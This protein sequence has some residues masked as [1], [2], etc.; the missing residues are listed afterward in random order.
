MSA[1]PVLADQVV[2]ITGA[3]GG[4]GYGMALACAE[5]SARV[6]VT[7]RDESQGNGVVKE[8]AERG[9]KAIFA[10][11]D[12][13]ERAEIDAAVAAALESFG[14]LDAFIHNAT[15]NRSP[16]PQLI[17]DVEA[18]LLAEHTS[19]ALRAAY[20]SAQAS[21]DALRARRGH[22]VLLTS[23]AGIEGSPTLPLYSAV[24]A[25]QRAFMKSLAKEWGPEGIQVNAISPLAA[26]PALVRA[27]EANPTM[28]AQLEALTPLGRV[29]DLELDI[30][31]AAVLLLSPGS[32]YI[33]GQ[34]W[35]VDGGRFL[36]L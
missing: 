16:E 34:T 32:H 6:V 11:C 15:S 2:L 28:K 31:A 12:V 3:G 23:P 30:G 35:V 22:F 10:R 7:A 13:T 1:L 5:A 20:Y 25:G 4:V 8:I 17:Q 29:G 21:F 27:F 19:V 33:T 14:Q 26:S 18:P 36:G 9:G 24:K